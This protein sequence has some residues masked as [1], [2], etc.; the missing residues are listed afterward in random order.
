MKKQITHQS[1]FCTYFL[2]QDQLTTKYSAPNI[3]LKFMPWLEWLP[4]HWNHS[5]HVSLS[6]PLFINRH[7]K[8]N[9]R[10]MWFAES[11]SWKCKMQ[12]KR[13]WAFPS[14]V[15]FLL[16]N[17][18]MMTFHFSFTEGFLFSFAVCFHIFLVCLFCSTYRTMTY[19]FSHLSRLIAAGK[20]WKT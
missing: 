19:T 14:H 12:S 16:F 4:V 3:F 20:V 7:A 9:A 6:W 15:T 11:H 8:H 17:H 2:P 1:V 5:K 18:Q 13:F 10:I